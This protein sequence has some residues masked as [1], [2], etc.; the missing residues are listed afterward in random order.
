VQTTICLFRLKKFFKQ[1]RF[2]EDSTHF[3]GKSANSGTDSTI[4]F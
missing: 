4:A 2:A 3:S 1:T